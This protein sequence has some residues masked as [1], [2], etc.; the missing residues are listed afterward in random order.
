MWGGGGGGLHRANS[1]RLLCVQM[2]K[3]ESFNCAR[4]WLAP[5]SF[6]QLPVLDVAGFGT[7]LLKDLASDDTAEI[8]LANRDRRRT[9]GG[10]KSLMESYCQTRQ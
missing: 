7:G 8:S 9:G 4:S 3:L 1:P 5:L 6:E 10:G 2:G